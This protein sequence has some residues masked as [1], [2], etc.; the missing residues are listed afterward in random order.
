MPKKTFK[1]NC[2]RLNAEYKNW[3]KMQD[4]FQFHVFIYNMLGL[5]I[6]IWGHTFYFTLTYFNPAKGGK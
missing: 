3:G 6:G 5:T 4:F 2:F 1:I